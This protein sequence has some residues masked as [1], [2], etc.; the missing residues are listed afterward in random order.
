MMRDEKILE[1]LNSY[2]RF[3]ATGKIDAGIPRDLAGRCARQ[4]ET[5][6]V[7]LLRGVRRSG[8]S[9]LMAQLILHLLKNG[10]EPARILRLNLE[11][12]LFAAELFDRAAGERSTAS[13]ASTWRP[14]VDA[15]SF[16][17]KSR[18]WTAGRS[19]SAPGAKPS[20]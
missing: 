8:K 15:G 10:T 3:W 17:T 6:E 14:P 13:T 19:G 2:N 20:R 18:T 5:K 9:T 16:S 4:L 1:I 12:P 7:L 11:E